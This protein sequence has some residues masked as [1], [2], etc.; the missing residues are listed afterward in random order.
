[1]KKSD[2]KYFKETLKQ[3]L[4]DL[5]NGDNCNFK[6]LHESEEPLP[7]PVDQAVYDNQRRFADRICER[8][9]LLIKKIEKSLQD[10]G[11]GVYGICDLCGDDISVKRLK[12]RPVTRYCITCKTEMEKQERLVGT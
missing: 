10:I 8:E 9:N 7:D 1:M 5:S 6:G 12:A 3:W 2:L 4:D 11:E